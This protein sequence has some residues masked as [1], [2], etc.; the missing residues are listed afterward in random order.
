MT[1]LRQLGGFFRRV[2][3]LVRAAAWAMLLGIIETLRSERGRRVLGLLTL[4]GVVIG[5]IYTGPLRT[6]APGEVGVRFNRVTGSMT[7]VREGWTVLLPGLHELHRYTLR[8]Q[9]YHP[10]RSSHATGD[11]PFQSVEGL[12]IGVD[13]SVRYALDPSHI[14]QVARGLPTDL[15]PQ[16]VE[17][18]ID[19]V[20][21]R[22]FAKHTV[23]EIF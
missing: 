20:L 19:G 12:S 14:T 13:V 23:R 5:V 18:V 21:H 6:I 3:Y 11:A 15:G 10:A 16:L 7:E 9:I 4:G 17:P 22:T 1:V 2:G 8:D